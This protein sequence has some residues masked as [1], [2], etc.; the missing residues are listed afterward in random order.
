MSTDCQ[1]DVEKYSDGELAFQVLQ[2]ILTAWPKIRYS[3]PLAHISLADWMGNPCSRNA[4]MHLTTCPIPSV[5]SQACSQQRAVILN[6]DCETNQNTHTICS[7]L[8]CCQVSSPGQILSP[9]N[10][11]PIWRW[12]FF[13]LFLISKNY[14][15][16]G[17]GNSALSFLSLNSKLK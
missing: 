14:N 7:T 4:T 6:I 8:P 15:E 9:H 11:S 12:F 13:F 17:F 16:F 10:C 1:W 5:I 3:F 2:P